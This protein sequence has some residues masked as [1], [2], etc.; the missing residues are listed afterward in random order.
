MTFSPTDAAFEGFRLTRREPRMFIA[1]ALVYAVFSALL[2]V[3]TYQPLGEIMRAASQVSSGGEP[4][5]AQVLSLMNAYG[6]LISITLLPSLIVNSIVQCAIM[7]AVLTPVPDRYSYLRLGKTELRVV[8]VNLM[9]GLMLGAIA[10]IGFGL[11]GVL[12]GFAVGGY[13]LLAIAALPIML[14]VVAALIWVSVR[15]YLAVPMTV[16]EERIVVFGSLAATKGHFWP[17]L[18]MV[19]LAMLLSLAV[20]FLGSI[21]TAPLTALTGGL[22]VLET[23]AAISGPMI[24]AL[25]VWIVVSA[26]LSAAQ[27]LILY[28]PMAVAWKSRK[29]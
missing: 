12:I 25:F 28:P 10:I 22:S 4:D 17:L 11:A 2:L 9:V 18:G 14:A 5:Q 23:S 6:R 15:L 21:V 7:R 29:A 3:V 16:T 8:A 1:L 13:P 26:A 24:A 19:L 27:L 20:S